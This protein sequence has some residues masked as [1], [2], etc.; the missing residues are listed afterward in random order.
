MQDTDVAR[1]LSASPNT[2][3]V[4]LR[5]FVMRVSLLGG[6]VSV[7]AIAVTAAAP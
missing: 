3:S 4:G 2:A 7:Q 5:E 6:A 1:H